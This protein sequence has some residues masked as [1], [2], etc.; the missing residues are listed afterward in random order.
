MSKVLV[1][2]IIQKET[3]V[4]VRKLPIKY[5]LVTNALETIFSDIGGDGFNMAAALEWLGNS[6]DFF[7]MIGKSDSY[8]I[9]KENLNPKIVL[10]KLTD[11]PAAVVLYDEN[12]R[13]QMFEDIKDLRY[14]PYEESLFEEK[15]QSADLVILSNTNFCRP[16]LDITK[17]A[18][19]ILAVNFHEY[20]PKRMK[21]NI[22]FYEAADIIY[23]SN[24]T[25]KGDP[26]EFIHQMAVDFPATCILMGMGKEG[27]MMYTREDNLVVPYDSVHIKYVKNT[28]GAGNALF[29]CFL[30]YY[31]KTNNFHDAVKY[32]LLFAAYKIGYV[33]TSKG[34]MTEAEMENWYDLIW[35]SYHS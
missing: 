30:H 11:T 4:K 6:V 8:L 24:S 5:S 35:N 31:L 15:I 23:V 14:V 3:I 18:N 29:S 33:G 13:Q 12:R 17:K 7:S 32:A 19:K 10:P 34:F 26:Y 9:E 21:Y 2:G 28:V 22:D 20:H 1:A 16:F 25:I 27:V